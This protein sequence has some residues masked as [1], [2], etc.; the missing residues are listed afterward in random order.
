METFGQ[1]VRRL[2]GELALREVARLAHLDP[3]HLSRVER[4]K[5][6]PNADLARALDQALGTGGELAQ[7]VAEAQSRRWDL[8]QSRPWQ[9]VE[10]LQRMRAGAVT[11]GT[12]ESIQAAAF[13][14]CC[15]YPVREAATLRRKAHGWLGEVTRLLHQPVGLA[16]HKELL[17]AAG[18]LTLLTACL[19]YDMG[20]RVGAEATRLG[21]LE[22]GREGGNPEIVGWAYEMAAWFALTQS[23][24]RDVLDA[25]ETGQAAAPNGSAA[26]QLAGQK[27]KAYARLRDTGAVRDI[28]EWGRERL[29]DMPYPSRT[30]HHFVVDPDKWDFYA[31]DAYRLARDDERA[32]HHAQTVLEL[33]TGPDGERPPMRMAEARL[34]L[35]AVAARDG[36]L[37]QAVA[38]GIG[39]LGGT[40]KSLP[41]LLMVAGELDGELSRRYPGETEAADFREVLD[42]VRGGHQPA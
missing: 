27:A 3:G 19:E 4:G 34:T 39:A 14:L 6:P 2:R 16:T 28:L 26:V 1:A 30:D 29:A 42:M 21:A 41:S 31:M 25:A 15:E 9:T 12:A 17:T 13:E 7:I 35:A 18:W 36:E 8:D 22:L 40:R 20:M 38:T 32:A 23:R 24:Y 33:G 37:E 10:L 5:R 11:P